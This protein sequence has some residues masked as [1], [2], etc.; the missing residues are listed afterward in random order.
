MLGS[1]KPDDLST[2]MRDRVQ[3]HYGSV[4]RA[5][6][7]PLL[8]TTDLAGSQR[9]GEAAN[10]TWEQALSQAMER[11]TALMSAQADLSAREAEIA[12]REAQLA[13][14]EKALQ[15]DRR[16]NQME[17]LFGMPRRA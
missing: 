8:A 10:A 5:G 9:G 7:G 17:S 13:Q 3:Q 15:S 6:T 1:F 2:T 11:S 16:R 4:V 14:R 12:R